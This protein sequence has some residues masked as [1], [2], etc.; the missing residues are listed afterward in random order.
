MAVLEITLRKFPSFHKN[1]P[2]NSAERLWAKV[3]YRFMC[4]E[5]LFTAIHRRYGIFVLANEPSGS[6]CRL[7]MIGSLARSQKV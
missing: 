1:V 4:P 7:I 5:T 2:L 3:K 6:C